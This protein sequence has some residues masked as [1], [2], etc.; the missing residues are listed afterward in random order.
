[1]QLEVMMVFHWEKC[2]VIRLCCER[3]NL[4]G[5]EL[6]LLLEMNC[7]TRILGDTRRRLG[8]LL[9]INDWKSITSAATTT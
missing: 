7:S 2:R 5:L 1:V 8:V 9:N 6:M 4:L 3:G